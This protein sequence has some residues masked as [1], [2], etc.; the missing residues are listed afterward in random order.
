MVLYSREKVIRYMKFD[1]RF[2]DRY[3]IQFL[4]FYATADDSQRAQGHPQFIAL[5]SLSLDVRHGN[6]SN[7]AAREWRLPARDMCSSD[8]TCAKG[9]R[10]LW[11]T[12]GRK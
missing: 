8:T 1:R 7:C 10:A 9:E 11:A 3:T 5:S 2:D 4:S 12:S 6:A